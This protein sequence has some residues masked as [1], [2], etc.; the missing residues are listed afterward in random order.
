MFDPSQPPWVDDDE[1]SVAAASVADASHDLVDLL[2]KPYD[3]PKWLVR[4]FGWAPGAPH[5]VAGYGFSGK[6]MAL[7]AAALAIAS[8]RPVWGYYRA[9]KGRVLHL[10]YEQGLELTTQRYRRLM[11]GHDISVE[12]G[13]IDLRSRPELDLRLAPGAR[14]RWVEACSGYDLVIIDSFRASSNVDENDSHAAEPLDMLLDVSLRTGATFVVIHHARKATEGEARHGIR[15]SAAIYDACASVLVLGG[16]KGEPPKA[17]HEKNKID[18]TLVDDFSLS[19]QD[20]ASPDHLPDSASDDARRAHARWGLRVTT[21]GTE[22]AEAVKVDKA[23]AKASAAREASLDR[24]RR[25]LDRAGAAGLSS[26]E[27]RRK[28]SELAHLEAGRGLRHATVDELLEELE[29]TG[30]VERDAMG[31]GANARWR[32]RG[33]A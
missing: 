1:E 2:A 33:S 6:T 4:A 13:A 27:V 25:V 7:Q 32:T 31:R 15:G 14:G 17:S 21:M 26:A 8:G 20:V 11:R 18:G 22:A 5:L 16:A 10:D 28:A 30:R 24:V 29:A 19:I 23:R 9:R 3:E 12:R